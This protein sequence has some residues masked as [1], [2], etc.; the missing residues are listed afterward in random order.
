VSDESNMSN[1]AV[2]LQIKGI[3]CDTV[4]C[5]YRDPDVEFCEDLLSKP[6]PKCGASLLTQEDLMAIRF[7]R[8]ATDYVNMVAG[9]IPEGAQK[10]RIPLSLNGTGLISFDS[11]NAED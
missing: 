1:A 5:D 9:P 6:C 4:G 11:G 2:E 7:L 3:K 8:A 10:D